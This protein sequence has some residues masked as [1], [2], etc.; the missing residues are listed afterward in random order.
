MLSLKQIRDLSALRR[1]RL[2]ADLGRSALRN[3]IEDARE[4]VVGVLA[5]LLGAVRVVVVES[6]GGAQGLDEGEVARAAR[7][8]DLA[9][10]E[11]GELDGQRACSGAAAVDQDRVVCL[12]AAG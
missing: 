4:L 12:S 1:D 8:D 6:L 7:R 11:D 3:A 10:G 9:A 5:D 2:R